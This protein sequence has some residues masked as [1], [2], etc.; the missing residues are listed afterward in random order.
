MI[1]NI[2][3]WI[4]EMCTMCILLLPITIMCTAAEAPI[5]VPRYAS[6]M[7]KQ[8]KFLLAKTVVK[9]SKLQSLPIN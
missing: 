9:L 6:C 8:L 2:L 5:C 3:I 4:A 1:M 7:F